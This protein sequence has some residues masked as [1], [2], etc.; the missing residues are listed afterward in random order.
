MFDLSVQI[1]TSSH[2]IVVSVEMSNKYIR[3]KNNLSCSSTKLPVSEN[4]KG[5]QLL[6]DANDPCS[7]VTVKIDL[8]TF[9]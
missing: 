2:I 9:K 1:S 8:D 6:I 5:L 7:L 3:I 4:T